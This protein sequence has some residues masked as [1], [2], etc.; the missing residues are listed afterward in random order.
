MQ[1][2]KNADTYKLQVLQFLNNLI[3]ISSRC[4]AYSYT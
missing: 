4:Y 1:V 3:Y 2:H